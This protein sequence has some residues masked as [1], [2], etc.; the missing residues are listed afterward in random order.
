MGDM[1]KAFDEYFSFSPEEEEKL[2][3]ITGEFLELL[4]QKELTIKDALYVINKCEHAV[5]LEGIG[6]EPRG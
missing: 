4:K 1:K 3:K 6:E 2:T 5:F